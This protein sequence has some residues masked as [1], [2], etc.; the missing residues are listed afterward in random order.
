MENKGSKGKYF[1]HEHLFF[2]SLELAMEII[3]G[4][5]KSMIIYFLK[6][7]AMRSSELQRLL[8]DI[9]NRMFTLAVRELERDGIISRIVYPVVPPKVEYK[10]TDFGQ[11]IVPLIMKMSDWGLS[12]AEEYKC[13]IEMDKEKD[14][15]SCN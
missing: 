12:A 5:W 8:R 2:C 9:S 15:K 11:T 1:Y 4:K 13:F 7:G 6:D 3:G 14:S 10:L